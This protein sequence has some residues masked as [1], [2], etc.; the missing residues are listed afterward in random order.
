MPESIP[1][2]FPVELLSR[3]DRISFL[4][5][6]GMGILFRAHDRTLNKEVSIKALPTRSQVGS[7]RVVRF[8]KEA[9]AAGKLSHPNIVQVLD[10]GVTKAGDP[11]LVMDFIQGIS[12]EELLLKQGSLEVSKAL[13]LFIQIVDGMSHAHHNG[14]VHRDIKSSN[15]MLETSDP[16]KP[17]A[18]IVDFGVAHMRVADIDR[19]GFDSTGS[20]LVGSP[21]YMGPEIIDGKKADQR[22]D[23]Y[24][25][26][27]LMFETVV[28]RLPFHGDTAIDTMTK[29]KHSPIPNITDNKIKSVNPQLAQ[30]MGEIIE[31]CLAKN[32]DDRFQDADELKIDLDECARIFDRD[33]RDAVIQIEIDRKNF[34][35][36]M[37]R[38]LKGKAKVPFALLF[39]GAIVLSSSIAFKLISTIEGTKTKK[40]TILISKGDKQERI[41][42]KPTE[43]L[44]NDNILRIAGKEI[45]DRAMKNGEIKPVGTTLNVRGG[46]L[47]DLSIPYM[48]KM[49]LTEIDLSDNNITDK[50]LE[51]IS[52]W[53]QL[54]DIDV[55]RIKSVSD[56]GIAAIAKLPKLSRLSLQGTDVS[57]EGL[58]SLTNAKEL[59]VLSLPICKRITSKG[60]RQLRVLPKLGRINIGW[61]N[62]S[63][64]AFADFPVLGHVQMGTDSA[65]TREDIAALAAIPNLN[66]VTILKGILHPEV[67]R[68]LVKCKRLR[69][70]KL[71][72]VEGLKRRDID[73]FE[74]L[75]NKT[76]NVKIEIN[77][78]LID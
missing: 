64:S 4:A 37:I 68:E 49:K 11:Y 59:S 20:N 51:Q 13:L 21:G 23:I 26:G 48:T 71:G 17:V 14:I 44:E 35:Q 66:S 61:T 58:R 39:V 42:F 62:V 2:G 28:G 74:Y 31:I 78:F 10:F 9:R 72:V 12:L 16:E 43:F 56:K 34:F 70:L 33:I 7:R 45:T 8:Q 30:A 75:H 18:I 65:L 77:S 50:G 19:S 25:I 41:E 1:Q 47:T 5:R 67:L 60:V 15:I 52:K 46:E 53:P 36:S 73:R 69:Y 63:P 55:D 27:C 76:N 38:P 22:S 3:Y 6:G 54:V 40:D 24:A 57:D 32:P 29:H